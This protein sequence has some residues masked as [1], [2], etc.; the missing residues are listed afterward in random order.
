M[1]KS[2]SVYSQ[3]L[4]WSALPKLWTLQ[5]LPVGHPM[6]IASLCMLKVLARRGKTSRKPL[7]KP[8][9]SSDFSPGLGFKTDGE[10]RAILVVFG[11]CCSPPWVGGGT[12]SIGLCSSSRFAINTFVFSLDLWRHTAATSTFLCKC[13]KPKSKADMYYHLKTPVVQPGCRPSTLQP[14]LTPLIYLFSWFCR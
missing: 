11:I 5:F 2:K 10:L 9:D 8:W 6:P 14:T 12:H 1:E 3:A 13:P 7:R 4:K